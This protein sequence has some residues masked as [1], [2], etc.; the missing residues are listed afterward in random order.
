MRQC[1]LLNINCRSAETK[2]HNTKETSLYFDT[3]REQ[4]YWSTIGQFYDYNNRL[5]LAEFISILL[6]YFNLSIPLRFKKQFPQS[7][8]ENNKLKHSDS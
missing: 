5:Q 2:L 4:Y 7:A 1:I 3:R 8:Q 6:S